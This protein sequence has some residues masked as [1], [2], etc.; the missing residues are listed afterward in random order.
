MTTTTIRDIAGKRCV[1]AVRMSPRGPA[2]QQGAAVFNRRSGDSEIA[3]PWWTRLVRLRLRGAAKCAIYVCGV[4]VMFGPQL[5]AITLEAAMDRALQNNPAILQAKSALE[6]AAGQ[7]LVLRSISYPDANLKGIAGA[8]GGHRIELSDESKAFGFIQGNFAQALFNAA[9][10]PSRR[11]GD[12]EILIAQEQLNAAVVEQLH[13]TRIAFY[14]ALYNRALASLRGSQQQQLE[15]NIK[16]QEARYQAGTTKRDALS[17]ARLQADELEPEIET[18]RRSHEAAQLELGEAMGMSLGV[19]ASVPEPE[20]DLQFISIP[21]DIQAETAN[22]LQH[23]ADLKLARLLVRAADEEKRI[24]QADYYPSV[25]AIVSGDYIP[26]S[27]IRRGGSG[28]PSRSDD[29]ISSEIRTGASYRWRIIDNGKVGG[30][31]LRARE[32]REINEILLRKVEASV[33]RELNRIAENLRAI[34]A[35]HESLTKSASVAEQ[36]VVALRQN[37]VQG[38]A[39]Q[40]EYRTGENDLLSARDRILETTYLHNVARAEWDRATGRYFQFSDDSGANVP[41]S[42]P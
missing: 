6:R 21:K 14:T 36:T 26:V 25:R 23:R 10:P 35:Q 39:S 9:I 17:A 11:R 15:E 30:A 40:I 18:A 41:Y 33:P 13:K 38:L 20:G 31:V 7:R 29:F 12:L 28:S 32:A 42:E 1:S 3:V 5:H 37:I 22:A 16:G 34:E 2:C 8:E 19:G 4:A 27:G 24:V